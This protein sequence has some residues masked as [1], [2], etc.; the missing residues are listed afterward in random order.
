MAKGMSLHIGL[1]HVDATKYGGWDGQLAGCL[2]DARD[3][4]ALARELGY[5]TTSLLDEK[6]TAARVTAAVRKAAG[7]LE[8]GDIFLLTYSG[9]GGQVP[10]T[11]GDEARR[12][13]YEIGEVPDA[14]DETW[15]LYDRQ[16]IDD[17]LW[18]LWAEFPA[19]VRVAVLSDSCHSGTVSR[20]PQITPGGVLPPATRQMPPRVA[21]EDGRRRAALYRRIQKA[22][23]PRESSEVKAS[24]LLISGC[25]DNQTSADGAGNGLFT[26]KL[27]DVWDGGKYRGSMRLLREA[28]VRRMPPW[29]TPNY[30]A[31]GARNRAFIRRRAL[32]I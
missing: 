30:Y 29:Q 27:L 15:V 23:P 3:M 26:E 32:H 8:A 2:N 17:E 21:E 20:A 1:N 11:N 14:L 19:K 10:D 25:Q 24:V 6:A 4:E 31:V 7:A 28:V 22:V 12:D 18:A 16:L 13:G 9:H 5:S